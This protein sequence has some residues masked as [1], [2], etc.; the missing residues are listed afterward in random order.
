MSEQIPERAFVYCHNCRKGYIGTHHFQWIP[1][2][3]EGHEFDVYRKQ[4]KNEGPIE[5]S[6]K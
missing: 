6:K 3:H 5:D 1:A 2:Q 4:E